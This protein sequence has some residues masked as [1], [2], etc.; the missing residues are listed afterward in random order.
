MGEALRLLN[1]TSEM[2]ISLTLKS[3]RMRRE[4]DEMMRRGST[5]M[6]ACFRAM[7]GRR[8][9]ARRRKEKVREDFQEQLAQ[10]RKQI[11]W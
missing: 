5:K 4:L 7:R 2:V 3:N 8:H 10:G 6:Q 11:A 1:S 9:T